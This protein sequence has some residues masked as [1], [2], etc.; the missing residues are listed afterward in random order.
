[1]PYDTILR[2][3]GIEDKP[4]P[5]MPASKGTLT[6]VTEADAKL[7]LGDKS[8]YPDGMVNLAKFYRSLV[9]YNP[10]KGDWLCPTAKRPAWLSTY[11]AKYG[12]DPPLPPVGPKDPVVAKSPATKETSQ[13]GV[14]NEAP[15][16][17]AADDEYR[18]C[19]P[20]YEDNGADDD[21]MDLRMPVDDECAIFRAIPSR[22]QVMSLPS[23][24][25]DY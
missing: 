18:S 24:F 25:V 5:S 12:I 15:P 19:V 20:P 22:D 11:Y 16:S 1:V 8:Q 2:E 10:P 6:R 3:L 9:V 7:V 23:M 4:D 13:S 17:E 14:H 21:S